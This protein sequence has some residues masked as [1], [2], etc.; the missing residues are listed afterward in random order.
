MTVFIINTVDAR[1]RI[2]DFIN[3]LTRKIERVERKY[4]T[5]WTPELGVILEVPDVGSWCW[6]NDAVLMI[7]NFDQKR[8]EI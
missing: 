7:L 6:N 8:Q 3:N 1:Q 5:E 2:A 4:H